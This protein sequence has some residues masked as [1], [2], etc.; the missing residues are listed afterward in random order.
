MRMPTMATVLLATTNAG[1]R[2]EFQSLLPPDLQVVGLDAVGVTLP[3]E[4]GTTFALNAAAKA[5]H[6]AAES[7][8]VTLADDSGL[9]VL[10]LGGAPGVRSARYA[11][12][13]ATDAANRAALLA[14][15]AGTGDEARLARFVC[16]VVIAD[17][18]G[19]LAQAEGLCEGR[20]ARREQGRFGFGYDR[21]FLLP[22]GRTM[23]ELPPVEKNRISH[24][25]AAYRAIVPRLLDRLLVPPPPDETG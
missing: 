16:V 8:L 23:A 3:T 5:T 6:A 18:S 9:E 17:G 12:E 14:A 11:G 7:G 25:A 4:T 2:A 24:R 22:D 10:A 19:V 15:L 1:K 20:I 13:H 21:L